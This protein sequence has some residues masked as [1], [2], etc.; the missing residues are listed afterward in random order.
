MIV[1]DLN[2]IMRNFN[3]ANKVLFYAFFAFC[4][5]CVVWGV[6]RIINET[7]DKDVFYV[8]AFVAII[9]LYAFFMFMHFVKKSTT[10]SSDI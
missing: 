10:D 1:F 5:A 7:S 6:E 9:L 4:F 3:R 2:H 8:V